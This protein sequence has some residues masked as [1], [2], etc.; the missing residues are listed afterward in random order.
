MVKKGQT[1]TKQNKNR[2]ESKIEIQNK[3][4]N[5]NTYMRHIYYEILYRLVHMK[6]DRVNVS[7]TLI[8]S[9]IPKLYKKLVRSYLKTR[10]QKVGKKSIKKINFYS[11]F[12]IFKIKVSIK[13]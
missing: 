11:L 10:V 4:K 7:Y 5:K 6:C 2:N 12:H 13:N 9:V 1:E 8:I 3:A